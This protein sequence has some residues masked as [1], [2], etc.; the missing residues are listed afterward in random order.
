MHA[1]LKKRGGSWMKP[2]IKI[3]NHSSK[4]QCKYGQMGPKWKTG[5]YWG[6]GVGVLGFSVVPS[7]LSFRAS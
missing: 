3:G 1:F 4:T 5:P 7:R 2:V 6:S